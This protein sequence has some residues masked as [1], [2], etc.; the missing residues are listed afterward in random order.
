MSN[1]RLEP[2][3]TALNP[4]EKKSKS[5][6]E[7]NPSVRRRQPPTTHHRLVSVLG[8]R[9]ASAVDNSLPL[10]T[11]FPPF[12]RIER[13]PSL[14]AR[15]RG[16]PGLSIS[17]A[18]NVQTRPWIR[19]EIHSKLAVIGHYFRVLLLKRS[20]RWGGRVSACIFAAVSSSAFSFFKSSVFS[21]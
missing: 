15:A 17:F 11:F 14:G 21:E 3:I 1:E 13:A 7:N 18:R 5:K 20:A 9:R 19:M 2:T 16:R 4:H 8:R 10:S 12:S 6:T